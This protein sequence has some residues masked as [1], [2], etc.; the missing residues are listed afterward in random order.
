[1]NGCYI[2]VEGGV[3]NQLFQ[4][5]TAYSYCKKYGKNLYIDDSNW[6]A[7]QG[8]SPKNY[9]AT[10]FKNFSYKNATSNSDD[11][12]EISFKYNELP[13]L[14]GDVS[15]IGYFQSPKYFNDHLEEFISNLVIPEVRTDFI[16]DKNVAFH[17]RRGDYL[18]Y[19]HI[20]DI[21]NTYFKNQFEKFKDYQINVFTDS[22]D[23]ISK[24]FEN[25]EFNLIQTS[26]ELN[27]LALI[28]KHDI[29]VCSNSSFSW[30][31]SALGTPRMVIAPEKWLMDRDCS[32]IYRSDMII[33]KI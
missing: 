16:K 5:A 25:Y 11:I 2:K 23:I 20:F 4:I 26:S 27:D 13:F 19:P 15:L 14:D 30:W 33:E 28:S 21:G 32:D 18:Y 12:K 31:A 9:E 22:P 6:T 3:G 24:E 17:I 1:M 7:S 29:I 10:I 8:K